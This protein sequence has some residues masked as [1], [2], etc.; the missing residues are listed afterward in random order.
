VESV[1]TTRRLGIIVLL[2]LIASA[3]IGGFY[4]REFKLLYALYH[5][6]GGA[7]A[8]TKKPIRPHF[9]VSG[10]PSPPPR[11]LVFANSENVS[12]ALPF[13]PS[14]CI[15][16]EGPGTRVHFGVYS[17]GQSS[18]LAEVDA[19]YYSVQIGPN[20]ANS[21]KPSDIA[22][23]LISAWDYVTRVVKCTPGSA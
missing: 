2:L 18:V 8:L 20:T 13:D 6:E 9:V 14:G 23:T 5:Y 21:P 15:A 16:L 10:G 4:F 1:A 17:N 3:V 11:V 19:G 7:V 12:S 22:L